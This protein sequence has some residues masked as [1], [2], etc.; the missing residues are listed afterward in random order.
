MRLYKFHS[1]DTSV[2]HLAHH[3]HHFFIIIIIFQFFNY[4]LLLK[5]ID[6]KVKEL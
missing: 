1:V 5:Y 6:F 2:I 3:G 4:F